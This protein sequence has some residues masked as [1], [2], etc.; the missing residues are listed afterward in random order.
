ML[1]AKSAFNCI[2]NIK[3][4]GYRLIIIVKYHGWIFQ[5]VNQL[6]FKLSIF[7]I[8]NKYCINSFCCAVELKMDMHEWFKQYELCFFPIILTKY[9]PQNPFCFF[10]FKFNNKIQIQNINKNIVIININMIECETWYFCEL[11]VKRVWK[12]RKYA[13]VQQYQ[14]SALNKLWFVVFKFT[15]WQLQ[16]KFKAKYSII[17]K[18]KNKRNQFKHSTYIILIKDKWFTHHYLVNVFNTF[19]NSDVKQRRNEWIW[20]F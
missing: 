7:L 15:L 8:W 12:I 4:I 3:W 20:M 17:D 19:C 10:F 13:K 9:S 16:P 6:S 11:F 1:L 2:I 5:S 18:C 14:T